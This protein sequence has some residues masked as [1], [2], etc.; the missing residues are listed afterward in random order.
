MEI[1]GG[2]HFYQIGRVVVFIVGSWRATRSNIARSSYFEEALV[3]GGKETL[4]RT[5]QVTDIL[6]K[7]QN[8]WD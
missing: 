4:T 6:R 8:Q 2:F 1:F 5:E 3:S 7:S